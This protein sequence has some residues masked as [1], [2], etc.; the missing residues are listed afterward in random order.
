[1]QKNVVITILTIAL[2]VL[3]LVTIGF[4]C[5]FKM[6]NFEDSA[7]EPEDAEEA[8]EVP[9]TKAPSALTPKEKEMFENIKNGTLTDEDIQKFIAEGKLTEKMVE[10]F[11]EHVEAPVLPNAP[12]KPT[13]TSVKTAKKPAPVVEEEFD[14]EGFSG[15]MFAQY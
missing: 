6:E 12:V 13:T 14:V 1:M 4:G 5:S 8:E 7:M 3:V 2:L 10:K 9:P 11:L 15:A